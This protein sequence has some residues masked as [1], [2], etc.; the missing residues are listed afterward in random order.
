MR[1]NI[2]ELKAISELLLDYIQMTEAEDIDITHDYYWFISQE[3]IY[4]PYSIPDSSDL[5]LGQ[6]SEDYTNLKKILHNQDDPVS[7]A[8]VWLSSLLRCLGESYP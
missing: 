4:N 1:V 8:L 6:L 7:Y 3:K 5:S 2:S